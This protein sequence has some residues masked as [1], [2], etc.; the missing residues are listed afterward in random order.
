MAYERH[1][2]AC[3]E[4]IT[5]A[6]MNNI[7]DGIEEALECC[8]GGGD[9]SPLIVDIDIHP[10]MATCPSPISSANKTFNE[11]AEAWL[12]GKR[13]LFKY[14]PNDAKGETPAI[15]EYFPVVG[16]SLPP[17]S[18]SDGIVWVADNSA[19]TVENVYSNTT[20]VLPVYGYRGLSDDYVSYPSNCA[21]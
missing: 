7:E 15:A 8:G 13:V 2:W 1:N 3:G 6:K 10:S 11:I 19:M 12:S 14:D 16:I 21:G 4:T 5:E 20:E 17:T 18:R 9:F